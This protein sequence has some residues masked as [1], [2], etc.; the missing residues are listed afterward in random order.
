MQRPRSTAEIRRLLADVDWSYEAVTL[1]DTVSAPL[2]PSGVLPAFP[3][4]EERWRVIT[5]AAHGVYQMAE[6]TILKRPVWMRKR[7]AIRWI[8]L[9]AFARADGPFLQAVFGVED[10]HL[11][12]EAPRGVPLEEA[13]DI[14]LT[15]A[16]VQ[17]RAALTRIHRAGLV[18]GAVDSS[19]VRVGAGRVILMLPDKPADGAAQDD[20]DAL[21]QVLQ[22]MEMNP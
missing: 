3:V 11:L 19:H 13:Q 15:K 2:E 22:V 1:D 12:I 14:D 21:E 10:E 7:R 16:E 6:D 18:H 4:S 20:L 5:S 8:E 9:T 17:L